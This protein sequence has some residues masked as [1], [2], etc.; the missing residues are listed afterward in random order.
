MKLERVIKYRISRLRS[1]HANHAVITH[2]LRSEYLSDLPFPIRIKTFD[3]L[4]HSD[5][6]FS[7]IS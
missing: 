7:Q 6:I 4:I 3:P 2:Y 5:P 1:N